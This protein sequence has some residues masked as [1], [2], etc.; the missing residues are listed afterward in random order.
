ML[1]FGQFHSTIPQKGA[2]KIALSKLSR[3]RQNRD[4]PILFDAY[5]L[6]ASA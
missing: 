4:V 6:T 2:E 1:I 5:R 3:K